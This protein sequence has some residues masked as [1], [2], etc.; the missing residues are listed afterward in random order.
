MTQA[1]A[2]AELTKRGWKNR[3]GGPLEPSRL[4]NYEQ[5]LRMP[6]PLLVQDLCSIYEE[7]PSRVYGFEEAPQTREEASLTIKYRLTDERGKK[8]LQSVADAQPEYNVTP[9]PPQKTG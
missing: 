2:A 7:F 9:G 4:G 5:G 3:Q 1:E 8:N 6:D